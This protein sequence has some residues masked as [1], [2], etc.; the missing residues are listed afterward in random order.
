M[1]SAKQYADSAPKSPSFF[2]LQVPFGVTW[3]RGCV[4]VPELGI[5]ADGKSFPT[6]TSSIG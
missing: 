2:V 5:T 3:I 6:I 1:A 4:F